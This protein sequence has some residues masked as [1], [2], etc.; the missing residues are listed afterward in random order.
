MENYY[1]TLPKK[2]MGVGALILNERNEL[3]IIKPSYKDHWSTPGG[4]V[5]ENESPR[6][7]CIR[8]VKEEVGL[9]IKDP[10]FLCVDWSSPSG[11]KGESLQFIFFGGVLSEEQ[12]KNIK[13][14]PR[15]ISEH[16]FL[17][18]DEALPL[19]SEKLRRRIPDCLDALKNNTAL[20][21]E[22]AQ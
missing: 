7:A 5:D 1:Q 16:K 2:R 10:K 14:A 4:T 21:L 12:V 6:N 17:P 18:L 15:E 22:D 9:E 3:L 8:E 13:L 11:E 19:L 20:Y